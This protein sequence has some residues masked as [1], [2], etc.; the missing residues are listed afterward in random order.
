[1]V[2]HSINTFGSGETD[3]L[4]ECHSYKIYLFF[5]KCV[6]HRRGGEGISLCGEPRFHPPSAA[7]WLHALGEL[8]PMLQ[9]SASHL[10]KERLSHSCDVHT[11]LSS[12]TPL[13]NSFSSKSNPDLCQERYVETPS[14]P[15]R[16]STALTVLPE[17]SLGPFLHRGTC[18]KPGPPPSGVVI[19]TK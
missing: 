17:A 11:F 9:D 8:G 4:G 13:V 18:S 5:P 6:S 14:A 15:A 3:A 10:Y 16:F 1:M 19:K 2:L 12:G 7:S